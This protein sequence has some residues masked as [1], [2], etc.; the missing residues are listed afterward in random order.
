MRDQVEVTS[1]K[2]P[3]VMVAPATVNTVSVALVAAVKA[4][5]AAKAVAMEATVPVGVRAM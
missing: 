5:G 3:A 2:S 4:R 1:T